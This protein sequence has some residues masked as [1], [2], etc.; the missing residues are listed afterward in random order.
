EIIAEQEKTKQEILNTTKLKD[1][2]SFIIV[3]K[4]KVSDKVKDGMRDALDRS[5]SKTKDIKPFVKDGGDKR[6]TKA[7]TLD[8]VYYND[9]TVEK[10]KTLV[11][12]LP[13]NKKLW[14]QKQC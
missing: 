13:E 12:A 2:T 14:K 8:T 1:T 11:A 6:L 10:L 3:E 7:L 5:L 9:V 4:G